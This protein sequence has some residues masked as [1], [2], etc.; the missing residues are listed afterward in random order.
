MSARILARLAAAGA[1]I[2][3]SVGV[4]ASSQ[5]GAAAPLAPVVDASAQASA[6]T[7][8]PYSTLVLPDVIFG[9]M[10]VSHAEVDGAP[11]AGGVAGPFYAPAAG[12]LGLLG[13]P[14][15]PP[16]LL[17]YCQSY[18]PGEPAS[19]SC[20][21]PR[22]G[23]GGVTFAFGNGQTESGGD[24]LDLSKLFSVASVRFGGAEGQGFSAGGGRT[25]AQVKPVDGRW[26]AGASLE[27]QRLVIGDVLTI[28]AI[29]SSATGALNGEP[30]SATASRRLVVTGAKVGGQPVDIT[31]DGVVVAGQPGMGA[32]QAKTFQESVD[33]ALEQARLQVRLLPGGDA[34]VADDGTSVVADSGGVAVAYNAPEP[35]PPG[36][37]FE[38]VF[39]RSRVRMSAYNPD[40]AAPTTDLGS[41]VGE[42]ETY[43]SDT[44]TT[45]SPGNSAEPVTPAQP[46][47]SENSPGGDFSSSATG[48]GEF[49]PGV[50]STGVLSDTSAP[51]GTEASAVTASDS[52]PPPG[53][54]T[55]AES[56]PGTYDSSD[57]VGAAPPAPPEPGVAL[58]MAR[59]ALSDNDGLG[60]R[61]TFLA[62]GFLA[63]VGPL[64][65]VARRIRLVFGG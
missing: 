49:S 54:D 33:K 58:P 26:T 22:Q 7:F 50:S 16:A 62:V 42:G 41:T 11:R 29:A 57:A 47:S 30:G 48:G 24:F 63:L 32:E 27:M 14:S 37:G 65:A 21:G 56:P 31:A 39:G 12:L 1:L 46:T 25:S 9:Q 44:S 36:S 45:P 15:V 59:T 61:H 13:L 51:P 43:S 20:G 23:N 4:A 8:H 5:A 38:M 53:S 28:D 19:A 60:V 35:V 6:G 17:P 64:L 40:A 34:K 52:A 10:G 55:A 2:A 18:F 3:G